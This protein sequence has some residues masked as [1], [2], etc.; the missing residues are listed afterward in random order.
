[1]KAVRL[2]V[3]QNLVNYKIP[4]SFQLKESYPLPPYSTVCG[5]VHK[6][7]GF[8]VYNP[9][10]IGIQ[11]KYNSKVNDLYTRY[12][13]GCK[14]FESERHYLK[15]F[16]EKMNRNKELEKV[17]LGITRGIS[18]VELLVDVELVIHIRPEEE[19]LVE[20]IYNK[21]KYPDEYLSLGRF[22]DIVVVE[23]VKIVEL[24]ESEIGED[25]VLNYES[26]IPFSKYNDSVNS[27]G[28]IYTLNKYYEKKQVKKGLEYRCWNKVKV[29]HGSIANTV[30]YEDSIMLKDNDGYIAFLA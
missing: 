21:L 20:T 27:V 18:T 17:P 28:T 30:I 25:T 2:K 12:E 13:F 5:M 1:M 26:Y 22:E 7:C 4:T 3:Y 16:D 15:V 29:I 8:E 10:D 11:G 24:N 9:M 19:C 23:D 14:T 6:A